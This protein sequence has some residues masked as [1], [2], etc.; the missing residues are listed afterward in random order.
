MI[1]GITAL[2]QVIDGETWRD[3]TFFGQL[4]GGIGTIF[5]LLSLLNVF[6]AFRIAGNLRQRWGEFQREPL[7]EWQKS[8]IDRAAFYLGV[9][10]G[11]IL[12]ELSHAL[13][14]LLFGGRIVDVG[15][16][17]YFGYVASDSSFTPPEWWLISLAG[18]IGSL[19]YGVGMWLIFHRIPKSSYRYF[20]NR[21]LRVQLTYSL[22][23]YPIFTLFTSF[24][25]W[26]VIYNFQ[27][28]PLLSGSTLIVHLCILALLWWADHR[29][30]FE[31]PGFNSTAEQVQYE[32]LMRQA[33]ASPHNSALQLQ[34]V[35]FYRRSG[36]N[37]T[38]RHFTQNFLRD[39][40]N[41]ADGYLLQ[42]LLAAH[43]KREVPKKARDSALRALSLG[44]DKPLAVAQANLLAGQYSLGVGE[45]EEAINYFSQGIGAAKSADQSNIAAELYYLRAGAQRR[46][47]RY[48][49]ARQ[50]IEEAIKLA[51]ANSQGQ[52]MSRYEAEKAIIED[53][54]RPTTASPP[55]NRF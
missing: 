19:V 27:A 52:A 13:F 25:D 44:L 53:H 2:V 33:T 38:A 11:V 34:M 14:I 51:R 30:L 7:Q 22:I 5:L 49:A 48:E 47:R 16:A 50:D 36:M 40:P 39:N 35:D 23:F 42:A 18:T 17:F 4:G 26:A 1:F 46:I 37:H 32:R 31:M 54:A 3:M 10:L 12:H 43:N 24:G 6:Y 8:I 15:Y 55:R 45:V 20:A 9:P 29:G 21:I 28:T 41:S